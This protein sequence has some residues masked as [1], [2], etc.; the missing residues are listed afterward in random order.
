MAE[1]N[2]YDLEA[3]ITADSSCEYL[4]ACG[5]APMAVWLRQEAVGYKFE[6]DVSEHLRL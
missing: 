6:L 4:S 5:V 2:L 1:K 3:K